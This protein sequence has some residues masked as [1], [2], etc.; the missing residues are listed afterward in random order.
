MK[1]ELDKTPIVIRHLVEEALADPKIVISEFFNTSSLSG[2]LKYLKLWR[3][4]LIP[5]AD[6]SK[7]SKPSDLLFNHEL[8]SKLIEA[9][10]LLKESGLGKLDIK[11][12]ELE[13]VA[14]WQFKKECKKHKH[15]PLELSHKEMASPCRV[16]K[17]TFDRFSLEEYNAILKIWLYDAVCKSYLE[18]SLEKVEVIV[19]YDNLVRLFEAM[20]LIHIRT[21]PYMLR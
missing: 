1:T 13:T 18:E 12:E 6:G 2:H 3:D 21:D 9:A 10:W 20:W 5:S 16:L 19:V 7:K 8:T 4:D 14:K 17:R 11:K 15:Y